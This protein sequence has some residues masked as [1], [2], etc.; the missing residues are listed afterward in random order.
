MRFP[1]PH[2]R[3][4]APG[5][6]RTWITDINDGIITVAGMELGLVGAQVPQQTAYAV[7]SINALVGA[8]AVFGVKL[9]ER[10][11][12]REAEADLIRQESDR[13]ALSPDDEKAELIAW[14]EERGVCPSTARGVADELAAGDALGAQLLIE[15][16]LKKR[17]TP[18]IAWHESVQAGVAFLLGAALPVLATI[19]TPWDTHVIWTVAVAATSLTTTS[20]ILSRRGHSNTRATIARS[21]IVGLSTIT[22]SYFLGDLLL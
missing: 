6:V 22:I 8:L 17:T 1:V 12:D 20:F 16:G 19:L 2:W 3:N 13:L 4:A 10:Y 21:L 15:Y 14:F 7:I 11:A 5:E 18:D 9:G